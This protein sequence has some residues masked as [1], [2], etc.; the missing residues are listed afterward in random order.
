MLPFGLGS[1]FEKR[2][3]FRLGD[4]YRRKQRHRD[5]YAI[6]G[7]LVDDLNFPSTF[8][9]SMP[10]VAFG[11]SRRI[12]IGETYHFTDIG[13]GGTV[14][15]VTTATV[16]ESSGQAFIG[17]TD[18][19]GTSQIITSKLTPQEMVDYQRHR[20][21]YFGRLEAPTKQCNTPYELFEWLVEGNKTK[22]RRNIL[23]EF[24]G[25]PEYA[26]LTTLGDEDLLI[27]Y[28]E[29]L[30][31]VIMRQQQSPNQTKENNSAA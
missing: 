31:E 1:D 7:S 13:D 25:H 23:K 19:R 28:A 6:L 22:P 12:L 14:G 18:M 24:G 10:S 20:D 26:R 4:L 3:T 30:V 21:A 2:G 9:G 16:D 8:D 27:E 5:A 17:I 29:S 11:E 15:T